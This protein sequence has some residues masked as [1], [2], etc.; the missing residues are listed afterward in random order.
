MSPNDEPNEK[1]DNEEGY[2][3]YKLK[4]SI[5]CGKGKHYFVQTTGLEVKCT[6][7][8]IGFRIQPGAE[9]KEGRIYIDEVLVV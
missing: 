8:P 9:I 7:C 1:N 2:E 6:K 3:V 5:T 4:P